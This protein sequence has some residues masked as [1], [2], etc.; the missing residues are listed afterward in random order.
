MEYY[1]LE[2]EKNKLRAE[3]MELDAQLRDRY[4]E[5]FEKVQHLHKRMD[6]I[7]CQLEQLREKQ[8]KWKCIIL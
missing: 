8:N 5:P 6:V 4:D 1:L 7:L 2:D 3:L